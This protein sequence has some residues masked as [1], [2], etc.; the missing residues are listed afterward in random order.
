MVDAGASQSEVIAEMRR[1]DLSIGN[2]IRASRELFGLSLREAKPVIFEHP[3]Y[4]DWAEATEPLH[5]ALEEF[6]N[7]DAKEPPRT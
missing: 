7:H 4:R 6:A 2:A 5:E 1:R 3:A